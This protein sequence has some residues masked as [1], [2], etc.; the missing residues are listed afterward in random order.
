[1][2]LILPARAAL[3][4]SVVVGGGFLSACSNSPSKSVNVHTGSNTSTSPPTSSSTST[5]APASTTS[6]SAAPQNLAVSDAVKS[7]L[8]AVYVAHQGLPAD[9][10]AGTA[11]GSVYYAFIPSTSTYWAVAS[12]VPTANAS[13]Q[14]QVAMQ[15]D[16]CCGIFT[17]ATGGNWVFVSGFLGEPCPGQIPAALFALWNLQSPGDCAATT[18]TGD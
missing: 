3:L 7:D 1:V 15:D 2:K 16:G 8:T 12:F 18:T 11:P 13:M 5:S 4:L 9:Q 17:M 14:T 6:T 10:V